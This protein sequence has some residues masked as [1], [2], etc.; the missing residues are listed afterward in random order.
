M[1][2]YTARRLLFAIPTLFGVSIIMFF[3]IFV[4]P[5][6]PL[7]AL[8][9]PDATAEQKAKLAAQKGLDK[10]IH[11]QYG[12]WIKN[13]VQGD[14]GESIHRNTPVFP[15]VMKALR[16]TL[17]LAVSAAVISMTLGAI[18]GTIAAFN[19]G[20][21]LDKLASG[22]AITGVSLPNYWVAILLVI[23]LAVSW[24]VLPAQ[25]MQT[26]GGSGSGAIDILKHMVIP[27]IAL[28]MISLGIITRMVRASV[29]EV[30]NREYVTALHAKGL[31]PV[32]VMR[33]VLKNAACPVMTVVGLDL[34]YLLGGSI[35]VEA[36]VNW[37]GAG[38]LL[39]L[40]IQQRDILVI[41]GT[42]LCLATIFVLINLTVDILQ[43]FVDPRIRRA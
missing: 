26:I 8:L 34:G 43:T 39:N 32:N 35:L 10:P 21:W 38:G 17:L 30:L 29:L 7:T 28:M 22:I 18:L 9:P 15:E 31:V 2:S 3:L 27:V 42:V 6:D 4:A 11:I 23:A 19:Q 33:H 25:G 37:P 12:I 20:R 5:G 16:N 24:R 40:A 13:A 41:Q 36:V 1:W 14:L